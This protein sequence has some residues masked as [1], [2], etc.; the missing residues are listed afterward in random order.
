MWKHVFV[1]RK[2]LRVKMDKILQ[3]YSYQKS[4]LIYDYIHSA[5]SA[6]VSRQFKCQSCLACHSCIPLSLPLVA[7]PPSNAHRAGF[8]LTFVFNSWSIPQVLIAKE[9]FWESCLIHL[10][11]S[12]LVLARRVF[13]LQRWFTP[14][15]KAHD[16]RNHLRLV[17]SYLDKNCADNGAK[18]ADEISTLSKTYITKGLP[19]PTHFQWL[20][21]QD[22][23]NDV[24]L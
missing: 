23:P 13:I 5:Q 22:L 17:S 15:N 2:L 21:C 3:M 1:I 16:E 18:T 20:H 12:D 14:Q 7:S 19:P 11:G 4:F 8:K 10:P 9:I 6:L 24:L